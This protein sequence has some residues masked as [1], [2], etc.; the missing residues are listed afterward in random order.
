MY[1]QNLRMKPM[2]GPTPIYVAKA[3]WIGVDNS[4]QRKKG[5]WHKWMQEAF[6]FIVETLKNLT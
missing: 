2:L 1:N 4:N 3:A 6:N 5:Q